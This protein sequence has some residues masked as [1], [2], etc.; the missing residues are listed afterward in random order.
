MGL[1]AKG[2]QGEPGRWDAGRE[3]TGQS[4]RPAAREP[5]DWDTAGQSAQLPLWPSMTHGQAPG[6]TS[7]PSP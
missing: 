4:H 1:A 5:S 3:E 7:S 6:A 2:G